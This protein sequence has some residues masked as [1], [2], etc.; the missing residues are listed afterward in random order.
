MLEISSMYIP[1][2]TIFIFT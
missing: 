1:Y 2:W